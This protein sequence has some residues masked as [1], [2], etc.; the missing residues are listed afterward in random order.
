MDD[1]AG[2]AGGQPGFPNLKSGAQGFRAGQSGNPE[3]V[4]K[5]MASLRRAIERKETSERVLEVIDAMRIDALAHEKYSPSAAKVYLG[6]VGL[7]LDGSASTKIDLS[8]APAEVMTYLEGKIP[9]IP[10]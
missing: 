2:A 6:A 7:K 9:S 10:S 1:T 4:S 3:G 8:D 5:Y